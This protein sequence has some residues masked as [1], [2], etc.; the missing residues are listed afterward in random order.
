MEES[1]NLPAAFSAL[2]GYGAAVWCGVAAAI[3]TFVIEI[4]LRKKG[5]LFASGEKKI[6]RAKRRGHM[7]T[8]VRTNIRFRDREP[9]DTTTNRL[10]IA[11]YEY[12]VDGKVHTKQVVSSSLKPP[13]TITLYYDSSPNKVFSEY[14]VG[15]NPLQI[16]LYIIPVLVAYLAMTAM[17]FEP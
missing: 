4:I 5:I 2:A 1:M 8:A 13:S 12:I 3:A 15:K 17:G 14:D 7:L 11:N 9:E 6:A 16:L 10:Y